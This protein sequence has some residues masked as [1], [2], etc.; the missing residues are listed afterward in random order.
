MYVDEW[1]YGNNV[2]H[3]L[4]ASYNVD[5]PTLNLLGIQKTQRYFTVRQTVRGGSVSRP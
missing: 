1:L 3:L 5:H 4:F 2:P